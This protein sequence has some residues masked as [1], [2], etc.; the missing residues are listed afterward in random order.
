M[1]K[2]G[3][4]FKFLPVI[5][6]VTGTLAS[7]LLLIAIFAGT[8]PNGSLEKYNVVH[9]SYHTTFSSLDRVAWS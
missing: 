4:A 9:V 7:I 1:P 3:M 5:P 8:S 6:I 2:F